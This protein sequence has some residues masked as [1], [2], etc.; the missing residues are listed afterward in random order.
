MIMYSAA[1]WDWHRMHYDTTF[2]AES[3]LPGPVVDG[4]MLGALLAKQVIDTFGPKAFLRKM[5]FRFRSMVFAGETIRCV[6]EVTAVSS[7]KDG[8]VVTVNQR[9]LAD[10]RVAVEPATAEV[11][12]PS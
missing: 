6:G 1:T 12:L 2:A 11:L 5:G 8:T 4:Q 7:G 10:D 3:G 9:V